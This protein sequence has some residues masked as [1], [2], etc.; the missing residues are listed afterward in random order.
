MNL[1]KQKNNLTKTK[2]QKLDYTIPFDTNKVYGS[3]LD[4]TDT[5]HDTLSSR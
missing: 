5:A 3:I 1:I 4:F 2:F